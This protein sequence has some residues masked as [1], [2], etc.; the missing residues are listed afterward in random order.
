M[1]D[2]QPL[3]CSRALDTIIRGSTTKDKVAVAAIVL[4]SVATV[5]SLTRSSRALPASP[6][7]SVRICMHMY[8]D[9]GDDPSITAYY[10]SR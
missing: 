6:Y 1:Q 5:W 2:S 10:P 3:R 8:P 7:V 9:A 4:A